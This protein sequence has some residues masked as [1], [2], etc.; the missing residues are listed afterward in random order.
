MPKTIG[1]P[2]ELRLLL[3][4]MGYQTD[5]PHGKR[6]I[7]TYSRIQRKGMKEAEGKLLDRLQDVI[8]LLSQERYI[9]Q[10]DRR[11]RTLEKR[12]EKIE[13]IDFSSEFFYQKHRNGYLKE[14]RMLSRS[15]L[16]D[17]R[18]AAS[19][20]TLSDDMFH[21]LNDPLIPGF[22]PLNWREHYDE[23]KRREDYLLHKYREV[24][25]LVNPR[26][27]L[28][29]HVSKVYLVNKGDLEVMYE[30]LH[31][32]RNKGVS[33]P[34]YASRATAKAGMR[35][36]QYVVLPESWQDRTDELVV[37]S[38]FSLAPMI[39]GT[40]ISIYKADKKG[41]LELLDVFQERVS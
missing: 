12:L 35:A 26:T 28:N 31:P 1:F 17:E 27:F 36:Y 4:K 5:W 21:K 39:H 25:R 34:W 8:G 9:P 32:T 15:R 41:A 24:Y 23:L 13:D 19:T 37:F 11:K 3:K 6:F 7:A 33:F 14:M 2:E 18:F 16:P 30:N 10:A 20:K 29:Y 38:G 40:K 22:T